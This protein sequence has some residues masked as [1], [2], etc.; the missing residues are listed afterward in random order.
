MNLC[1]NVR[2]RCELEMLCGKRRRDGAK[3]VPEMLG[4]ELE[5]LCGKRRRD[6]AKTVPEMLGCVLEKWD[7]H[8]VKSGG[9]T[10]RKLCQK[11]WDAS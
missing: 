7:E 11:Y 10:L 9:G 6:G 1:R 3:S 2:L 4:C 8:C 5:M